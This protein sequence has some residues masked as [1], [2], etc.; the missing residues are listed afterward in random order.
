MARMWADWLHHPCHVR[1]PRR[2]AAG[3]EMRSGPQVGRLAISPLP[4]KAPKRLRAGDKIRG[5]AHVGRLATSHLLSG[6]S[7]KL[8]GGGQNHKWPIS[9]RIGYITPAVLVVPDTS[10]R[11]TKSEGAHKWADWLNDPCPL[12][13]PQHFGAG[14]KIRSGPALTR[15][16]PPSLRHL[17]CVRTYVCMCMFVGGGGN[18]IIEGDPHASRAPVVTCGPIMC[19]GGGG[20]C[21]HVCGGGGVFMCGGGGQKFVYQ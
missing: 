10:E 14:D 11:V 21:V 13:G 2:F 15:C 17:V 7:P 9:E 3:D 12:G 20:K 18:N 19:G 1:S 4:S 5:D 6:S 8:H 16:P